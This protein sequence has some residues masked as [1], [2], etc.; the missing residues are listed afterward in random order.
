MN[1]KLQL[2]DVTLSSEHTNVYLTHP[3][4]SITPSQDLLFVLEV[5]VENRGEDVCVRVC[6]PM[7]VCEFR[8]QSVHSLGVD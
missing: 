3:E 7:C 4:I 5:K 2:Q 1:S 6:M 8:G